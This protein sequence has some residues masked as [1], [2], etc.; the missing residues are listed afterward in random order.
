M[1]IYIVLQKGCIV[2]ILA[3]ILFEIAQYEIHLN[4]ILSICIYS[5]TYVDMH[6]SVCI[7]IHIYIHTAHT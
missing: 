7:C 4:L 3:E 6:I 5:R 2:F 1:N